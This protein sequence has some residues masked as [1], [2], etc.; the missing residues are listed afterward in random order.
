M[1][2]HLRLIAECIPAHDY[3]TDVLTAVLSVGIIVSYLPQHYRIISNKSSEGFSPWFLLLGSTASASGLLNMIVMQWGVLKCC[4]VYSTS[5]CLETV[6]GVIQ[7]GFQWALFCVTQVL[8]IVYFP[9]HLKYAIVPSP[10]DGEPLKTTLKSSSWSLSITLSWVVL[11]HI[12]LITFISFILI[13]TSPSDP[14]GTVR[15]TQLEL[16]ATFLGVSSAIF[17]ALQYAPQIV[18][19]YR[20]KLVG[21]LSIPMMLMQ[22]PGGFAMTLSII[23]RPGTNWTS[24]AQFL[25]AAV[26]QGF[27]LVMCITWKTRQH[28]LGIDDFG[29]P[30][31]LATGVPQIE[32]TEPITP[33]SEEEVTPDEDSADAMLHERTPLLGSSPPKALALTKKRWWRWFG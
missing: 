17:A 23:L 25:V 14:S 8:Y 20:L 21:A 22:T 33:A 13:S 3:F 24:W 31:E 7:V 2:D 19:T 12:I 11:I 9:S 27:L 1:A 32:V 29:R 18:H 4:N 15:S 16:W 26:M 10:R 30:L 5:D 28:R 6:G